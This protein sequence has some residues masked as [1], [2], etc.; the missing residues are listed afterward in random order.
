MT[1]FTTQR[2]KQQKR[3]FP[4]LKAMGLRWI[5]LLTGALP[6]QNFAKNIC[7]TYS[8][9]AAG[10]F[11]CRWGTCSL[12]TQEAE[13]DDDI[14]RR[15]TPKPSLKDNSTTD[16]G[17]D[18]WWHTYSSRGWSPGRSRLGST[19]E[20]III[21]LTFDLNVLVHA[22]KYTVALF[23]SEKSFEATHSSKPFPS[24]KIPH[25]QNEDKCKTFFCEKVFCMRI[26]KI[27]LITMASHLA[28]LKSRGLAQP[29]LIHSPN[30]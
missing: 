14:I 5:L 21:S 16:W 20:S 10:S 19:E 29:D 4:F 8:T 7:Y 26:K 27:I 13:G 2:F 22:F 24:S 23:P 30:I 15:Q 11:T 18:W 17:T 6:L 9:T 28:S 25:F 3:S 12:A 1:I